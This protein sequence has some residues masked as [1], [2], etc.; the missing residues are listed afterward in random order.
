[1]QVEHLEDFL[2]L[3]HRD[4]RRFTLTASVVVCR[5]QLTPNDMLV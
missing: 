2:P 3:A 1:M 4:L 5:R